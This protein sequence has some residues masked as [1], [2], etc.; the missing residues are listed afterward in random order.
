MA[1]PVPLAVMASGGGTN[2]EALLDHFN[3]SDDA[4][5]RVALVLSDRPGAVA[6]GRAQRAGVPGAV[7]ETNGREPADVADSM[8]SEL[9]RHG[10]RMIALAGYLKLVPEA[11]VGHYRGRM[12]NIHP[13]LLPSFGGPGFYGRRV[14]RAVLG[15]GCTVTGVTVHLVDEEY[16]RGRILAQ[17]PVP[18][19]ADDSVETLAARVL[20]VEHRLY[21]AV[22]ERLARALERPGQPAETGAAFELVDSAEP[23]ADG[24]RRATIRTGPGDGAG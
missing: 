23:S 3:R 9:E 12:V 13:S 21:P 2:L 22:I 18:V 7:V 16:D 20:R 15:S 8:L 5:V 24:I 11:V 17:Y 4:P 14:H 1:A 10:I 6:L 19:R